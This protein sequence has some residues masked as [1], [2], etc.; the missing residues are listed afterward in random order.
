MLIMNI[1]VIGS[2]GTMSV[3]LFFVLLRCVVRVNQ[4]AKEEFLSNLDIYDK[5]IEYK[6][7]QLMSLQ[8]EIAKKAE[9]A[10]FKKDNK[11]YA[12]QPAA[13]ISDSIAEYID[14]DFKTHYTLLKQ[15]FQQSAKECTIKKIRELANDQKHENYGYEIKQ[16]L[17]LFTCDVR[18]E[19]LMLDEKE[20]WEIIHTMVEGSYKKQELLN[21]YLN[22]CEQ[23]H[24]ESF[25]M[26]LI[27]YDCM[28]DNTVF[29]Y[30]QEGKAIKEV[31]EENIIYKIDRSIT[32]GYIIKHQDKMYDFS[33]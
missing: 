30:S 10:K 7:Q 8:H 19:M 25:L 32:E 13:I 2:I 9:E 21:D 17:A 14:G 15:I 16:M 18:Y 28:H 6:S 11:I 1:A 33:L 24:W 23:V 4:I 29:V 20:Q 27:E 22:G 31:Q 12:S 5:T 3:F 26:F